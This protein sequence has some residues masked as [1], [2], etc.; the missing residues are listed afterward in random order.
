MLTD[1]RGCGWFVVWADWE[2]R[3]PD[4]G[5]L[6]AALGYEF[7]RAGAGRGLGDII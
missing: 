3:Y 1:C 4:G 6:Q 7:D 5:E 2:D